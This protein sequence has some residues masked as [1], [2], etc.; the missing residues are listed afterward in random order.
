MALLGFLGLCDLALFSSQGVT[1]FKSF[2]CFVLILTYLL[3]IFGGKLNMEKNPSFF[4]N[5]LHK[6]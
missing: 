5:E 1:S 3:L 4:I 6:V 2:V